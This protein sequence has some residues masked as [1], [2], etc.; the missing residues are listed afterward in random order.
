MSDL[1]LE[2]LLSWIDAAPSPYHAASNA[3]KDLTAAGF[4]RFSPA[5]LWGIAIASW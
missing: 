1:I 5:E 4:D 2:R 3:A